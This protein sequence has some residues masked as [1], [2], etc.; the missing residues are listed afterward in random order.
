M[1]NFVVTAPYRAN[2]WCRMSFIAKGNEARWWE[3]L[4]IGYTTREVQR[5][6]R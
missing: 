6:V 4:S 2:S 1:P 5:L 3:S